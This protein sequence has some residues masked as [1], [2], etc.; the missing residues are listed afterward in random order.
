MNEAI[1]R[2]ARAAI[3]RE[4]EMAVRELKSRKIG[5]ISPFVF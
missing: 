5:N 4:R 1:T 3:E 2:R